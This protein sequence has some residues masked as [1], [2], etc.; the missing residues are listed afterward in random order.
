MALGVNRAVLEAGLRIPED[1]SVVG[2]DGLEIGLSAYPPL[3]TVSSP[4][5]QIAKS[6]VDMLVQ[7]IEMQTQQKDKVIFSP[8]NI[9]LIPQLLIRGS[10]GRAPSSK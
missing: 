7:R 3:T 2:S 5:K 4:L 10:T 8:Q 1:I 9:R 6:A